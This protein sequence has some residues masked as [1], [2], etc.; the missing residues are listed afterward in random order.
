MKNMYER[1]ISGSLPGENQSMCEGFSSQ[2]RT[3]AEKIFRAG[4]WC[5]RYSEKI[6]K[7]LIEE[8]AAQGDKDD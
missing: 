8:K 2:G 3:E 6:Y 5:G 4:F 7:V 1:Y